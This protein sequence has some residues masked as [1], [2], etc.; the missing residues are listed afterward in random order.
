MAGVNGKSQ[1][2]REPLPDVFS[3]C[4][5]SHFHANGVKGSPAQICLGWVCRITLSS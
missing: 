4:L 3:V 5:L 2:I 1:C